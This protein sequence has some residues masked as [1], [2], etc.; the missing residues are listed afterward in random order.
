M[1]FWVMWGQR[2]R[3]LLSLPVTEEFLNLLGT[4]IQ[5]T[6]NSWI[7][8][9]KEYEV[10]G[11]ANAKLSHGFVNDISI[12]TLNVGIKRETDSEGKIHPHHGCRHTQESEFIRFYALMLR[13]RSWGKEQGMSKCGCGLLK[14]D[15]C[16]IVLQVP[17]VGFGWVLKLLSSKGC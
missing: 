3:K 5:E 9:R 4:T 13:K 10:P 2:Q 15:S 1:A 14:G 12:Q 7:W 11:L 6:Q 16:F 17:Y 8:H